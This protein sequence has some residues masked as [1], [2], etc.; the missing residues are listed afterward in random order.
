M[1]IL[2]M[3]PLEEF[4]KAQQ[5]RLL[6]LGEVVYTKDRS[7]YS[8]EKLIELNNDADILGF[9]PDNIGGFEVSYDRLTKLIENSSKLKGLALST[10]A[11]GY[12]NHK[13]CKEKSI[14]VTNVPYYSTESVAEHTIAFLLGA[15]KRIIT[16]DRLTQQNKYKLIEGFELKGKTLGIIG[17]GNIGSRTAELGKAIGMNIIA[18]NR[19]EKEQEGI[20]I[21]SLDDVLQ[22][23][24]AIAIHL[25][26]N[27][28]TKDLLSKEKISLL[29]KGVIIVNTAD[30]EIVDEDAIAEALKTKHVDTYVLESEDHDSPPL[31]GI[32]NAIQFKGFG[33]FTKEALE[34]NKEIWIDNIEGIIKG[35]PPNIVG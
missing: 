17:L 34:R 29:K 11:F 15:A 26:E 30:R 33:W 28:E 19:S 23:S 6:G 18:W 25:I 31:G 35:N 7:E 16:T 24:D 13:L 8:L 4:T 32:E 27:D 22:E 10:T 20:T 9:D 14:V 5:K 1:K 2:I 3:T 21:K 12:V